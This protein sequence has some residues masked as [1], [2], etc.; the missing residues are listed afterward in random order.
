M[1]TTAIRALKNVKWE[2]YTFLGLLAIY[3]SYNRNIISA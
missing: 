3:F 2:K 1:R